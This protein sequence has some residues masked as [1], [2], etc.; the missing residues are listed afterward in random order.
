MFDSSI[1]LYFLFLLFCSFLRFCA[2]F[3]IST[4]LRGSDLIRAVMT[5]EIMEMNAS[6]N[7]FVF[8][9]VRKT[10]SGRVFANENCID[11][12]MLNVMNVYWLMKPIKMKYSSANLVFFFIF[13]RICPFSRFATSRGGWP[14]GGER[15]PPSVINF[16]FENKCPPYRLF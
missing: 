4:T 10:L 16:Y 15:A 1:S 2:G 11:V 5:E 8:D 12:Q 9:S 3:H 6:K 7:T 14:I 13:P